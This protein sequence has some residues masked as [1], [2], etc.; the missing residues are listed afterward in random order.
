MSQYTIA[1]YLEEEEG[2][3]VLIIADGWDELSESERQEGSFL[4]QL[5]F[6]MFPFISVIVTSRPSASASLHRLSCIDQFV[7]VRGFSKEHIIEYI[8]S[9]F[10]SD[11]EKAGR[12]LEQLEN[13]P[14][15]ESVCSVPLNCAIVCHLW[16]TLEEALPTTMTDLYK[17]IILNFILRNIRKLHLYKHANILANFDSLPEGL[18][19]SWWRLCAFAFKTLIKNQ[20]VFSQEEL[21]EFFSNDFPL[22]EKILCFGLMQPNELILPT[23]SGV[24]YHFL[25]LTFQEYLAALHLVKQPSSEALNYGIDSEA[26]LYA[27]SDNFMMHMVWR[28][29][30]GIYFQESIEGRKRPDMKLVSQHMSGIKKNTDNLLLCHCTFEARN[31]MVID[32]AIG[33]LMNRDSHVNTSQVTILVD[34]I[35]FGQPSTAHDCAAILYV[36]ANIQEFS[37]MKL[38]FGN[39]GIRENQIIV[40]TDI[41]ASKHGKKEVKQ[42]SLSG[43]KLSDTSI[44]C[45]LFQRASLAFRSLEDLNLNN[46]KIGAESIKSIAT[47]LAKSSTNKLSHLNLSHNPL[48]VTGLQALEE[49][50]RDNSLNSLKCLYLQGCLTVDA[51]INGAMLSTLIEALMADSPKLDKLDLSQNNLGVPGA[52]AVT[53]MISRHDIE[54]ISLGVHPWDNTFYSGLVEQNHL[55]IIHLNEIMLGD[56]GLIAFVE[57][58][59]TCCVDELELKDNGIHSIAILCRLESLY[60]EDFTTLRL[61]GNP[62]GLEGVIAI[63]EILGKS[64]CHLQTLGLSKCQLTGSECDHHNSDGFLDV[65][66]KLYQMTRN[67][68]ITVLSLREN[69]FSGERIHIL[70]GLIF[71]C[72]HLKYLISNHCQINSDDI[73]KLLNRLNEYKSTSPSIC[74]QLEYWRLNNNKIDDSGVSTLLDHLPLLFPRLGVNSMLCGIVIHN[75]PVSTEMAMRVKE[76][77]KKHQEVR[78]YYSI[79]PVSLV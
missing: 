54:A 12:L 55:R 34:G 30:F 9:E 78:N 51:D 20:I 32:E 4:Y 75:N 16:R 49:A 22:D 15:V 42:L 6:Q 65:E 74:S 70:S 13:N 71:M 67:C 3:S 40:L 21:T 25:H 64:C 28:F 1:S 41:L 45:D 39:C 72:I 57:N 79:V 50:V 35:N 8:H 14:L 24:S 37:N 23:G 63:G 58:L 53:K 2:E 33:I 60:S 56:S 77:M 52:R 10:A 5:L 31:K 11:Q 76:E 44:L 46:N 26:I 38:D 7:E 73:K 68:S 43:S 62:L 18:K 36:I 66:R 27:L 29:Y 19:Y 48:G 47:V 17:K 59:E 61:S 69:N